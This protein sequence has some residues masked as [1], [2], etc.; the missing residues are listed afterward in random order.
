MAEREMRVALV[1]GGSGAIGGA[2]AR[3]LAQEGM[4]VYVGYRRNRT[5]AQ[6]VVTAI[7]GGGTRAEAVELDIRNTGQSESLCERIF[8][9]KGRL[10]VLVNCA[11]VISEAPA[12]GVDDEMWR[13]VIGTNLDGT[14][15]LCRSAAK[16]MVLRQWGRIV[17][18]SSITASRGG[19]GHINYAASKAGVEALTRVLAIELG[20]KGVLVNCVAPGVIESKMSRRIREEHGE[21]LRNVI[22]VRRFGT[23]EEVAD[24]VTFLASERARYVTGQVVHVDGG[25]TL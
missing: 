22:A 14:F 6:S 11:A 15:A 2:V 5:A 19:R 9:R 16:Y 12:L 13:E 21:D 20:R 1:A 23:P 8:E 4:T 18:V 17:N 25:M 3:S 24:V 7:A 10:D